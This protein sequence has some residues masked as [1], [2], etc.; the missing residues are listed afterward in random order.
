MRLC[1]GTLKGGAGKTAT[2]VH[3]ALGLCRSG[4]TLLVDCD[5]EQAQAL[6]WSEQAEEWPAERCTV[7]HVATRDLGR[8]VGPMMNDYVHV[9]FDM[10]AKNP[11]LLRQAL[12][13]SDDL[14]IPTRPTGGDLR[15]LDKVF[16]VAADID[17]VHPLR[18]AVLLT[19][20]RGGT[21][22]EAEARELL[23]EQD[24]P[25]L[26]ARVGMRKRYELAFGTAP[27]D[28]LGDYEDVLKEL[29]A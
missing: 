26:S 4:R 5:P 13:L 20:V 21:T 10:G 6:E 19:Q 1:I 17:A 16:E 22:N 3:L 14:I 27:L 7:I 12:S 9:V 18:A 25:V 2:A 24:M 23:D 15:E 8:R 29:T 11:G 28:D